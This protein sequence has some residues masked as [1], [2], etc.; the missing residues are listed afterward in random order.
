MFW[1]GRGR[2]FGCEF[3]FRMFCGYGYWVWSSMVYGVEMSAALFW[4][5]GH[6]G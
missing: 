6:L 4:R 2:W 3:A 1:E 5:S